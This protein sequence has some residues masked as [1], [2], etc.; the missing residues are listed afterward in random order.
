MDTDNNVVMASGKEE[1]GLGKGDKGEKI[2]TSA[3][4]LTIKNKKTS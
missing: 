2:E 3:I 4:V 1:L